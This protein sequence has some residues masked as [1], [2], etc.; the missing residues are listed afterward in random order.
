MA[1]TNANGFDLICDHI[2]GS[3]LNECIELLGNG[4]R[5]V[6]IGS[7]VGS[8]LKIDNFQLYRKQA[9]IIGSYMGSIVDLEEVLNLVDLMKVKPVVHKV[10]SLDQAAEAHRYMEE[11]RHFGKIVLRVE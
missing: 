8:E 2:G 4:G 10:F 5:L 11:R 6:T 7:T 3:F 9:S 1:A